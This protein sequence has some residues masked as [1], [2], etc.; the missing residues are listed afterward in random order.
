MALSMRTNRL[1]ITP[2]AIRVFALSV[3]WIGIGAYFGWHVYNLFRAPILVVENPPR[4]IMTQEASLVLS[5]YV[6]KESEVTVNGNHV[7]TQKDGSFYDDI[8]LENGMNILE[9][10]AV[11][12]FGNE[13]VVARRVV[14][15]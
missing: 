1:T 12:K 3:V 11:N 9:V 7:D 13:S 5:G 8:T 15:Q 4:D 6:K 14:K 10:R 2:R